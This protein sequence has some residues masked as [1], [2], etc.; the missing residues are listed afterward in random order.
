[1]TAVSAMAQD[2]GFG[3]VIVMSGS[4]SPLSNQTASRLVKDL[5]GRKIKKIINNPKNNWSVED[6][7]KVNRF[8]TTFNNPSISKERQDTLLIVTHKIQQKIRFN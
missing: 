7:Q 4:V 6:T 5:K 3:I 8:I 1:M 2:N